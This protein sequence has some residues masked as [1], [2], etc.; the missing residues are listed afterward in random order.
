ME[1]AGM[2]DGPQSDRTGSRDE[3]FDTPILNTWGGEIGHLISAS[4]PSFLIPDDLNWL[5]DFVLH[6]Y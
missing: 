2:K 4:P 1:Y 6:G 5:R 3:F